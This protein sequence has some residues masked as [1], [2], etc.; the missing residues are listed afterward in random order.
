MHLIWNWHGHRS[1]LVEL[2][3]QFVYNCIKDSPPGPRPFSVECLSN[4][5]LILLSFLPSHADTGVL[6]SSLFSVTASLST[7]VSSHCLTTA[8]DVITTEEYIRCEYAAVFMLSNYPSMYMLILKISHQD[9]KRQINRLTSRQTV[10]DEVQPH[11]RG[12]SY[13]ESLV[14]L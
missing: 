7:T 1:I 14:N 11:K 2:I 10:M 6:L 4:I 3:G 13:T 9:Q 8:V 12:W 5:K